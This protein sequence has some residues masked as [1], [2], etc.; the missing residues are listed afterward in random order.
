VD[1]QAVTAA[2]LLANPY[3]EP[4]HERLKSWL[5]LLGDIRKLLDAWGMCQETWRKFK[6]IFLV[7]EIART[8]S[9]EMRYFTAGENTLIRASQLVI[10]NPR[11]IDLIRAEDVIKSTSSQPYQVRVS[12]A[13][14]QT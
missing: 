12:H 1:D 11:I 3:S 14:A 13:V 7:D 10:A 9:N 5:V 8:L 2:T 4:F 6:P